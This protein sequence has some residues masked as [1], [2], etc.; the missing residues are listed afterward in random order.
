MAFIAD[1]PGDFEA[2]DVLFTLFVGKI[3]ST[4]APVP[5]EASRSID[6]TPV[7]GAEGFILREFVG[8]ITKAENTRGGHTVLLGGHKKFRVVALEGNNRGNILE[9]IG[10]VHSKVAGKLLSLMLH[11]EENSSFGIH[12][13][14]IKNHI[15]TFIRESAG[16][17]YLIKGK[18]GF[19]S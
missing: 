6:L 18:T 8:I 19:S 16:N 13:V 10:N 14:K 17:I 15:F 11:T 5:Y 7:E 2:E 9:T 12:S 1:S 4:A 3:G